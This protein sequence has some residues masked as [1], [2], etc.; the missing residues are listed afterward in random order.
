MPSASVLEIFDTALQ[1]GGV[2][3]SLVCVNSKQVH[4]FATKVEDN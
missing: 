4:A 1:C 2:R 3:E